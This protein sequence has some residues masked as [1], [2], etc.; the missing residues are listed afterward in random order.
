MRLTKTCLVNSINSK[1]EMHI[2]LQHHEA[3]HAKKLLLTSQLD[4][5]QTLKRL[6]N[7][8]L[9]R[10]REIATKNRLKEAITS[11]KTKIDFVLANFPRE[12]KIKIK[13][14]KRISENLEIKE[15]EDIQKEL[16]EIKKKLEDLE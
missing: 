14:P 3:L 13:K 2:K 8:E 11:L 5:I 15:N 9:Y 6:K 1:M 10:K 12:E 16:E 7:Y 4:I